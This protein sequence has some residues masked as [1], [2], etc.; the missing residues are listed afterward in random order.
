LRNS[1]P[2]WR[3]D[4]DSSRTGAFASSR[5]VR[6]ARAADTELFPAWREHSS[7][8]RSAFDRMIHEGAGEV[9]SFGSSAP[10][11]PNVRST[12]VLMNWLVA[13]VPGS[14]D[15][16]RLT[17]IIAQ[18]TEIYRDSFGLEKDVARLMALRMV[19]A[20]IAAVLFAGPLGLTDDD[21]A[22]VSQLELEVA[23]LLAAARS[24]ATAPPHAD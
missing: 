14:L 3:W 10:L 8:V 7:R 11:A 9:G 21:V 2:D 20:S 4:G 16:P 12:V 1:S 13:A 5:A 17:L 19:G 18:V 24:G 6:T 23:T 22:A 15:G